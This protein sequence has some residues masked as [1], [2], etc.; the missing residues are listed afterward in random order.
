MID[1]H[2]H[3]LSFVQHTSTQ[4]QNQKQLRGSESV[5]EE[6]DEENKP[7]ITRLLVFVPKKYDDLRLHFI[8]RLSFIRIYLAGLMKFSLI[9]GGWRFSESLDS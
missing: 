8:L 1:V 3:H 9:G 7:N 5:Q 6:S 2:R 4:P